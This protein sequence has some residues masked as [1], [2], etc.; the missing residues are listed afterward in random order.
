MD[1]EICVPLEFL[2][3]IGRFLSDD[4]VKEKLSLAVEKR[5]AYILQQLEPYIRQSGYSVSLSIGETGSENGAS[6]EE[7][8]EDPVQISRPVSSSSSS[9]LSDDSMKIFM[10][11]GTLRSQT[12]KCGPL[13]RKEKVVF[14]EQWRR[15]A[16][17]LQGHHM[18]FYSSERD[19]KPSS[20]I[21]IE[22]YVARPAPQALTDPK[23]KGATFEIVCPGKRDY[24]FIAR[25]AK[26]MDQWV[27]AICQASIQHI[28]MSSA[29]FPIKTRHPTPEQNRIEDPAL[30]D[31]KG[32]IYDDAGSLPKLNKSSEDVNYDPMEPEEE[33]YQDIPDVSRGGNSGEDSKHKSENKQMDK[34]PTLPPRRPLPSIPH[35]DLSDGESVYDDIGQHFNSIIYNNVGAGDKEPLL[36]LTSGGGHNEEEDIYDDAGVGYTSRF[37]DT[38]ETKEKQSNIHNVTN[39]ETTTPTQPNSSSEYMNCAGIRNK[40][41]ATEP[42]T[43]QPNSVR[44]NVKSDHSHVQKKLP[45]I[46]LNMSRA[47]EESVS[48]HINNKPPAI[49]Q[50][51][52]K[53][54]KSSNANSTKPHSTQL[55]ESTNSFHVQ[56][57]DNETKTNQQCASKEKD[58]QNRIKQLQLTIASGNIPVGGHHPNYKPLTT[59]QPNESNLYKS[60]K[61][62]NDTNTSSMP[63]PAGTNLHSN[64]KSTKPLKPNTSNLHNL[65]HNGEATN[66]ASQSQPPPLP[67]RSYRK[68]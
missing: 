52:L 4:L 53:L 7:E 16:A 31:F 47:N 17:G 40:H 19:A 6:V 15:C 67:P 32:D 51:P 26:D 5:R 3:G 35:E 18:I 2:H 42:Q 58:I 8:Y 12:I 64:Y 37:H 56:G 9:G 68:K 59:V 54:T 29:S 34:T 61:S 25:T 43:T 41:K 39:F 48:N 55:K 60:M 49:N 22:G 14:L 11:F 20:I 57:G 21:N 38:I 13:Y 46:Q 45:H 33:I 23:K 30:P 65:M 62:Y 24:Q 50:K 66:P 10:P 1:S 28:Q 63:R 44:V 36:P 27:A